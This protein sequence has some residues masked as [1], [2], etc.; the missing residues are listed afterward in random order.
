MIQ[1]RFCHSIK[2]RYSST[3]MISD[4][5]KPAIRLIASA[6]VFVMTL[7][8]ASQALSQKHDASKYDLSTDEGVTAAREALSNR[9]IDQRSQR[10]IR[11]GKTLPVIAVGT[12]AYD[13]GCRF[14]GAF[15][16]AWYFQDEGADK[17]QGA[18][19]LLDWQTS[20]RAK[21][22][23]L[24]LVWVEESW[25][26]FFDIVEERN[27]DFQDRSFQPPNAVSSP[28]GDV[29]V[30]VW[31]KLP[32]GR[33]RGRSYELREFKFD[34]SGALVNSSTSDTFRTVKEGGG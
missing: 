33:A 19:D 3:L 5:T 25:L 20:N 30:S 17:F 31:I 11:R 12:F 22:E 34:R 10:C 32:A 26:A 8:T 9:K 21:R 7:A 28:H 27:D 24:A 18:L 23:Q 14:D 2:I 15:I 6:A 16:K 29:V 13:R 1:A 4:R